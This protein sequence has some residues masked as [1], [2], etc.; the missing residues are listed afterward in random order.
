MYTENNV[1][2]NQYDENYD[3]ENNSTS[4]D[5]KRGIIIKIVIIAICL[6]VLIWLI[7]ALKKSNNNDVAYDPGVHTNNVEKVRL[8]AEKYFFLEDNMPKKG[9]VKTV[10]VE[11]LINK[12]LTKEIVDYNK[13]VCNDVKSVA[14]LEEDSTAY[15]LKIKL[16]CS[17]NEDEETFYYKKDN[18]ACLNCSGVTN[19]DGTNKPS[20][21]NNSDNDN[22]NEDINGSDYS[23]TEWSEWSKER[24]SDS[25]LKERTRTLVIGVKRGGTKEKEVYSDWTE[26]TK[27][28][29]EPINGMEVET[30]IETE[31]VWSEPKTST[32]YVSNS[33][34]VKLLS[35]YDVGG[36][37]YT[38]CPNGYDVKDNKCVSQTKERG[39]LTYL[40][41]NSGDYLIYNKPCDAFNTEID[42]EGKYA[43]VYKNCLYSK[44]TDIKTGYSAGYTVYNYQELVET[45]TVYYRYRTKTIQTV[46]EEDVYTDTLYEEDKLPEGFVKVNGSEIVEYSYMYNV[47]EK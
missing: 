9:E 23:C 16:S 3:E 27:T 7:I 40:E 8:A 33:E 5:N 14:T 4:D 34:T 43:M 21:D 12:G 24:V 17:T 18:Y 32:Y 31:K 45:Q 39:D 42:S 22:G 1:N 2:Y 11:T 41:Y 37:S 15:V 29:F 10:T 26:Y 38:H 19:M 35:T 36:G 44:I 28:P 20:N 47:C 6:V 46:Q 13:K 25:S 30:K